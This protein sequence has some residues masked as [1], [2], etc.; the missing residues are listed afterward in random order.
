MRFFIKDDR[1]RPTWRVLLYFAAYLVGQ[2]LAQIPIY[3]AYLLSP[4]AEEIALG[5]LPLPLLTLAALASLLSALLITWAFRRFLDKDTLLGLGLQRSK[6]WPREVGTGLALG[7]FL[8]AFIF[9]LEW[10]LGWVRL[11]GFAWHWRPPMTLV[12]LLLG[13]ASFYIFVAFGEEIA[14]RGY[15]LQNL[16]Q[17]WGTLVALLVSSFL[18]ALLHG[19]NPHF[20]PLALVGIALAG[21]FMAYGYLLSGSLWLPI[22]FHFA[23]NFAQGPLFSFPVS[24]LASEGLLLLERG[25]SPSLITGGAFGPEGGIVGVI[26]LLLGLLLL[27]LCWRREA[28]YPL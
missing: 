19:L 27:R 9:G 22:A 16:R 23:W 2:L 4:K 13:Y 18:F 11:Q 17:D 7:F 10:A 1:L 20:T 26:A 28:S 21:V 24:G 14:F 3:G 15:I 12:S 8:M 25:D 6:R 5:H